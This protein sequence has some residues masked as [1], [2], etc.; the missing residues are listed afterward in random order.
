MSL[1]HLTVEQQGIDDG[2][3]IG[4]EEIKV[5]DT[6]TINSGLVVSPINDV[7]RFTI[8]NC[9]IDDSLFS[10]SGYGYS[11]T[12]PTTGDLRLVIPNSSQYTKSVLAVSGQSDLVLF[13]NKCEPDFDTDTLQFRF[14]M[15]V[16][17]NYTYATAPVRIVV[18]LTQAVE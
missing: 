4:C 16:G 1:N 2:L 6:I 11:W 15:R 10:G 9:N 3:R 13:C 18:M 5:K 8:I 17:S 7:S 12:W 14:T